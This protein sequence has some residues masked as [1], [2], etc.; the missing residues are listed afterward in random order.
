MRKCELPSALREQVGSAFEDREG[1]ND[2][3]KG[4]VTPKF[5]VIGHGLIVVNWGEG[6]LR[7]VESYWRWVG[8]GFGYVQCC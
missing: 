1:R 3:Q 7:C 6:T 8:E 5:G 4:H 2:A